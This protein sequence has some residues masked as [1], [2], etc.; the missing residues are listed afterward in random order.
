MATYTE[1]ILPRQIEDEMRESY[2][3][4]SMSVIVSCALPDVRDGLKPVDR[5]VLYGMNELGMAPNRPYKKS[6][7]VVGEVLGKYHPHGD[8]AVYDSIVRMAQDFSMRGILVD[9]QGNFGSM[10]G[11]SPAAMRYTEIRL[12]ALATEL[13]RDLDKNTVNFGPNVDDTL[14]QPLVMPAG[15]PNLLVNG[16]TGI[17]VGMATNIPPHNLGEV[18]DGCLAYIKDPKITSEE[19]MKIIIAPDFPTGGLI[20]GYDSVRDAYLTGRGKVILRARATV[21]VSKN[22]RES[23][24][25]T[26]IPYMVNKATLQE[27][28]G[29]MINDKKIEGIAGMRDESDKDGVRIV[30]DLKRDTI[31]KVTLNQLYKHS[32]MQTTFGVIMLAL[33][34]GVPK[35]LPLR[36]V[37]R[38]YIDHRNEV[39]RRRT[40]FDLD[41]AEKR[42]HILEGYIIAL[43]NIDEII[44][45]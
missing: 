28:I 43:D 13:L 3:D 7:R 18:I 33:V 1:K 20:Y 27:K 40:Q 2:I 37:I 36:D 24:I 17:A 23:I 22:D 32:Q 19:L 4:Y 8:V 25:V 16:A 39:I 34:K 14:Q 26:E 29:E 38:H 31:A 10:D 35:V 9:G 11:D 41:A 5:R 21:E 6:A 15:F 44:K 45:V 12:T 42:A 30:F